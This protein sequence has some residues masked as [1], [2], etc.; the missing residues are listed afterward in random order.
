QLS[1]AR[2]SGCVARSAAFALAAR[3]STPKNCPGKL[4]AKRSDRARSI[5]PPP[6]TQKCG[7]SFFRTPFLTCSR[8]CNEGRDFF[9][10]FENGYII[11]PNRQRQRLRIG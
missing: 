10:D 1:T 6:A 7:I 9:L 8:L 2:H 11:C 3:P 5:A 4:P